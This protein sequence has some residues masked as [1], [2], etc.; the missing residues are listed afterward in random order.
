MVV[1]MVHVSKG[2]AKAV[3]QARD[4]GIEVGLA[5]DEEIIALGPV[6]AQQPVG[7]LVGPVM[8]SLLLAA[9]SGFGSH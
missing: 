7:V 2:S 1:P 4:D 8:R 5:E 3:G 9:E 6:L